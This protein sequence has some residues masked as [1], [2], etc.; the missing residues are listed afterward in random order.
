MS[1]TLGVRFPFGCYHATPWDKGVNDGHVEWPPSPWRILRALVSTWYERSDLPARELDPLLE[2]LA[3][4]PPRYRT[5]VATLSHTRHYMPDLNHVTGNRVQTDKVLD[6]FLAVDPQQELLI[7]WDVDLDDEQV[8]QLQTLADLVPYLGRSESVCQMRVVA[9]NESA[10]GESTA[11]WRPLSPGEPESSGSRLLCLEPAGFHRALLEATPTQLRRARSPLRPP[12]TRWVPYA[13]PT[14]PSREPNGHRHSRSALEVGVAV[15]WSLHS[16]APFL[17]RYGVMATEVLRLA[18]LAKVGK[19][20]SGVPSWLAGKSEDGPLSG[21]H[22]HAHWL[23]LPPPSEVGLDAIGD[24]VLWAPGVSERE[25]HEVVDALARV[26]D[27]W[28]PA[29]YRPRGFQES[30]V[31]LTGAG[32]AR[33]VVPELIADPGCTRW[34]SLTPILSTRHLKKETPEQFIRNV[35]SRELKFRG[36]PEV[37]SVDAGPGRDGWVREHRRYRIHEAMR[38]GIPGYAVTLT[39]ASP[40]SGPIALG[41]LSHFGFGLFRPADE[42]A[43]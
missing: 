8:E 32:S 33:Q 12:G 27:L 1:V 2:R 23:W 35:V 14:P 24:L 28:P 19:D 38:D 43:D 16:P 30:R 40:V 7:R 37:V 15:R 11:W 41:A 13:A 22:G 5:P 6:A 31:V 18:C 20:E 34:T 39:L 9:V 25:L 42:P 17:S 4:V 26:H 29:P 36:L 21:L 10:P 3:A